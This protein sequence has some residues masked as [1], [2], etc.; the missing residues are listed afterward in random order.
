[1]ILGISF[2]WDSLEVSGQWFGTNVCFAVSESGVLTQADRHLQSY[3]PG[4]PRIPQ[5]GACMCVCL[6]VLDWGAQIVKKR[7]I[8]K[9]IS[10]SGVMTE[11]HQSNVITRRFGSHWIVPVAA[12]SVPSLFCLPTSPYYPP[13]P[14]NGQLTGATSPH[15]TWSPP[16]GQMG[17]FTTSCASLCLKAPND[18]SSDNLVKN[19]PWTSG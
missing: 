6:C 13:H 12:V 16:K 7:A 17:Q 4:R 11:T 18:Y 1:M 5:S 3:V 10:D 8:N 19:I 15:L 14:K 9:K 2:P